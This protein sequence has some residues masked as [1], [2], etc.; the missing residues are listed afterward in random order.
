MLIEGLVSQLESSK[1]FM[2]NTLSCLNEEDSAFVPK[3]GMMSVCQHVAHVGQC[4]DWFFEGAF[5]PNGFSMDFEGMAKEV[6]AFSSLEA[7]VKLHN[8]AY[9]RAIAVVKS[10]S[11]DEW[12]EQ[13]PPGIMEGAPKLAIVGSNADHAAHH[14]GA[15]AVYARL[16]GKTPA[17]PYGA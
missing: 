12:R 4:V 7:A 17:M 16:L 3:E 11:E 1:T 14:R 2:L 8:E 15:L 9:D 5:S 6:A 10:K 13:L